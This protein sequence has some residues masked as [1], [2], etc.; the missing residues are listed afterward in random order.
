MSDTTDNKIENYNTHFQ[1]KVIKLEETHIKDKLNPCLDEINSELKENTSLISKSPDTEI[2]FSEPVSPTFSV[3]DL[4]PTS[5]QLRQEQEQEQEQDLQSKFEEMHSRYDFCKTA[6]RNMANSH[7]PDISGD[8]L[9]GVCGI[10]NMGNT[11]YANSCLQILR[12]AGD[13]TAFLLSTDLTGNK[14]PL[15]DT[16]TKESKVLIGYQDM[17]RVLWS[18]SLPAFIRPMGWLGVVREAVQNSVY[19]MFA[20]PIPNDSHEYLVWLLDNFH[21]ALLFKDKCK[22]D[23]NNNVL[24]KDPWNQFIQKNNTRMADSFFGLIRKEIQCKSCFN[25]S[26]SYEPFNVLKIPCLD[27]T[28]PFIEWFNNY[29]T[30]EELEDYACEK[31][32][33]VRTK[34][35][36]QYTLWRAPRNLFV[37]VRRFSP[38]G[39]KNNM[40]IPSEG[41]TTIDIRSVYNSAIIS[42][43][44]V[45]TVYCLRGVVDH[46]GSHMG[47]HY[48]AQFYHPVSKHWW[49]IDDETAQFMSEPRFGGSNYIFLYRLD[50]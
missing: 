20:H 5:F 46:H 45:K 13:W 34:A 17:L 49:W 43:G 44:S 19:E 21:E 32:N 25:H 42:Q 10:A 14:S 7:P 39:K 1:V 41:T 28:R 29:F 3:C 37:S 31:C 36:I 8:D 6:T 16:T 18:A 38:D 33:P 23:Y 2:L 27:P 22:K 12:A 30:D 15:C 24:E 4:D 26:I 35:I 50:N 9:K 47:G 48:T 40:P 11:C